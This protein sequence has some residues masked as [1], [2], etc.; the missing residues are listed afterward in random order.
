LDSKRRIPGVQ[1]LAPWYYNFW[2]DAKNPH[3]LWRR[4]TLAE[5]RKP[6]PAW[7]VVIDVDALGAAEKENW[8]WHGAECLKPDYRLCLV[9]L[10]RGG[11]DADVVREFDLETRTFVKGGFFLPEAK[12]QAGWVDRDTL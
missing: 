12:S 4:T 8:V 7:E 3:G 10:S 2:K 9:S 6:E 5:Y 1:R 11:A